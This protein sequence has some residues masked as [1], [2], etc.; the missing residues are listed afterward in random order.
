LHCAFLWDCSFSKGEAQPCEKNSEMLA[1]L[2]VCMD[3]TE[4]DNLEAH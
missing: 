1:K 2:T 4:H 3:N